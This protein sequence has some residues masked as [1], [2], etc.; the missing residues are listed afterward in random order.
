VNAT[1]PIP[2]ALAQLMGVT[3][4]GG[5]TLFYPLKDFG[6]RRVVLS[7]FRSLLLSRGRRLCFGQPVD[8][9][10]FATASQPA[11]RARFTTRGMAA[12]QAH[13]CL[14]PAKK[15]LDGSRKPGITAPRNASV[16]I[17]KRA[18]CDADPS[19]S[20]SAMPP[21][22]SQEG[23]FPQNQI[24]RHSRIRSRCLNVAAPKNSVGD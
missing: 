8:P 9:N 22:Y 3:A 11:T 18:F 1:C 2:V 7:S 14:G 15:A 12:M 19:G 24:R 20:D 13:F 17:T 6:V 5:S 21:F 23:L 4:D 10:T 16:R